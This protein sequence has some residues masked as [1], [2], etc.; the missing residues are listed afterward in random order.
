MAGGF[1]GSAKMQLP[2]EV[3]GRGV[4]IARPIKS[5]VPFVPL[6]L[7]ITGSLQGYHCHV[8]A[9]RTKFQIV[10][11]LLWLFIYYLLLPVTEPK[12]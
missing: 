2:G 12:H 11:K 10:I 8:A 6:L 5:G 4:Q 9:E 7:L 1:L 3:G